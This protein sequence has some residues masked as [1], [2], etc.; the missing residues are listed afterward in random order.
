MRRA[1]GPLRKNFCYWKPPN[2]I[3]HMNIYMNSKNSIMRSRRGARAV[4]RIAGNLLLP[5]GAIPPA[6]LSKFMTAPRHAVGFDCSDPYM[7]MQSANSED[8]MTISYF[9]ALEFA[10]VEEDR[11]KW[12]RWLVR[13]T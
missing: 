5:S 1:A 13:K 3:R 9:S 7:D 8:A 6:L 12:V 2:G 4:R 10:F 11:V